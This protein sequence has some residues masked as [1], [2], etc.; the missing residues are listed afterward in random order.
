[1]NI[2]Y[3]GVLLSS[4]MVLSPAIT[5]KQ[6][7]NNTL[8]NNENLK[9]NQYQETSKQ[10]IFESNKNVY[11]PNLIIGANYNRLDFDTRNTQVGITTTGF[12][13]FSMNLYNGGK[14]RALK[15]QKKYEYQA[16]KFQNITST[17]QTIL[18]I[19]TLY[20][21][22]KTIN[23]NIKV[24]EEK[25]KALYAQYERIKTK[26]DLRMV[27]I[28]DVLKIKSEYET[29]LYNIEELKYQKE[30]ILKNIE[31]LSGIKIDS[32]DTD[33]LPDIKG[34]RY[35][36]TQTIKA[37]EYSQKA[38]QENIKINESIKKPQIKLED[39]YNLYGYD[40]YDEKLL[41]D[42]PDKQNQ[43]SVSI[44]YNLFDTSSKSKIE[45][46]K[47]VK[48]ATSEQLRFAKK[49]SKVEFELAK[50]R[51]K[52][53]ILKLKS[54]KLAVDMANSVYDIIKVK[55]ENGVVDNIAYLDALSKKIYNLAL[56]KAALNDLEIAKAN[57]YFKSGVNYKDVLK[58]W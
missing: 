56:Y 47:L 50:K 28:D 36:P 17:K 51:I 15:N 57:Y 39:S 40:K 35:T 45:S 10:K 52:T 9:A 48:L 41:Q 29:N 12:V 4:L 53:Q 23:E 27:T 38:Q 30:D 33:K 32:L 19:V 8:E 37:L 5:L 25:S 14:N 31:L 54:L 16:Q 13:K 18:N 58:K 49:Q 3:K 11:N 20:F 55:Y 21:N 46:A 22:L 6:L 26:Y 7:I 1:M 42:L 43:F 34:L 2:L 24:Y 44:T